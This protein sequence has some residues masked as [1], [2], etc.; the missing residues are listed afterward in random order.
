MTRR[1]SGLFRKPIIAVPE[2]STDEGWPLELGERYADAIESLIHGIHQLRKTAPESKDYPWQFKRAVREHE[3]R[4]ENIA[5]VIDEL[6]TLENSV[7]AQIGNM[8][9]S[10]RQHRSGQKR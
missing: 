5:S 10:R 4:I 1:I 3:A 6:Q 8:N 9:T 7:I 2:I